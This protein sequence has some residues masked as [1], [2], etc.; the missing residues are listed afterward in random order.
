MNITNI[1][2][3]VAF[4]VKNCFTLLYCAT[5]GKNNPNKQNTQ[6]NHITHDDTSTR[7]KPTCTPKRTAHKNPIRIRQNTQA[8]DE[9]TKKNLTHFWSTPI[10][11]QAFFFVFLLLTKNPRRPN[12][13][14]H[15]HR[16]HRRRL[17]HRS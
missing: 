4:V 8:H 5:Q 1:F 10:L 2:A 12:R 13:R 3:L 11:R 15:R 6:Q 7:R 14:H 9:I 17:R 16:H